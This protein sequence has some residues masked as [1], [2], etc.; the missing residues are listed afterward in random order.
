L[1]K[2]LREHQTRT[3]SAVYEHK[4]GNNHT[5]DLESTSVLDTELNPFKRKIKKALHIKARRPSLNKDSGVELPSVYDL[6]MY[7]NS[8]FSQPTSVIVSLL[9]KVSR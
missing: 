9:R 4:E 8:N 7:I 5:L 6:I 3:Q 1:H 2:R